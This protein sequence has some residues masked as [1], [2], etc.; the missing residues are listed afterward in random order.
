MK[1]VLGFFASILFAAVL[2]CSCTNFY[3]NMI[4]SGEAKILGF[5]L[6][7]GEESATVSSS[8]DGKEISV[9]VN[10]ACDVRSLI[11]KIQVSDGASVIPLTDEYIDRT[12]PTASP[13]LIFANFVKAQMNNRVPEFA[14]KLLDDNPDFQVPALDVPVDFTNPVTFIVVA[15]NGNTVLY[16]VSTVLRN[17]IS[18]FKAESGARKALLSWKN[19]EDVPF[20]K[21]IITCSDE[22]V[23]PIEILSTDEVNDRVTVNHLSNGKNYTFTAKIEFGEGDYGRELSSTMSPSA[24]GVEDLTA[25]PGGGEV[26]LLW[27]NPLDD[28]IS[29]IR[30]SVSPSPIK[31]SS[32]IQ[33]RWPCNGSYVFENLQNGVEYSFTVCIVYRT[34]DVSPSVTVKA[35]PS[36]DIKPGDLYRKNIILD[37]KAYDKTEESYIVVPNTVIKDIEGGDSFTK[38]TTFRSFVMGRYEL[39][40]DLFSAIQKKYPNLLKGIGSTA[41]S[42]LPQEN[43]NIY[44]AMIFCN[45]LSREMGYD[46][47]Y[48][49][50]DDDGKACYDPEKWFK[51]SRLGTEVPVKSKSPYLDAW[52][53]GRH[54]NTVRNGYRLPT[55]GEWEYAFRGGNPDSAAWNFKYSGSNKADEV[56]WFDSGSKKTNKPKK[57][58]SLKKNSLNLY[59]MSGNV[60]EMLN[61][62]RYKFTAEYV[63]PF[64]KETW[65][66]YYAW[67]QM[68]LGGSYRNHSSTLL[69]NYKAYT[70]KTLHSYFGFPDENWFTQTSNK[71]DNILAPHVRGT[72]KGLRLCRTIYYD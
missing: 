31:G 40:E 62:G 37:G 24:L 13:T 36:T 38:D 69:V 57:V 46:P 54:W 67:Y 66:K 22:S 27:T 25:V 11:P 6:L 52:E 71:Y 10:A 26:E 56:G 29:Y 3:H 68:L 61:V 63:N 41:G 60:W 53:E 14:V 2:C 12:F 19:P 4:P 65:S 64:T 30:I 39:T 21:I 9:T 49:Y 1:N 43:I 15:P 70:Y 48:Y 34:G 55:T 8:I 42:M 28:D 72:G 5:E 44:D 58:G 17:D 23:E 16:T 20:N 47:V 33:C 50:Y 18:S 59:D 45:L 32:S 7:S 51:I 35:T